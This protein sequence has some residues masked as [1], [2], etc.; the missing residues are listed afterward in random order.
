MSSRFCEGIHV[1]FV[2]FPWNFARRLNELRN[3][4]VIAGAGIP[5]AGTLQ[6]Q[7]NL[8]RKGGYGHYV[9]AFFLAI[10]LIFAF[11]VAVC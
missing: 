6:A 11:G 3:G 4:R 7:R 5:K 8:G 2:G 1:V 9:P 10:S